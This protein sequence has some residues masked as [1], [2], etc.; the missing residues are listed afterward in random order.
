M[1]LNQF[2]VHKT[3]GNF[4][5]LTKRARSTSFLLISSANIPLGSKKREKS[6]KWAIF[7]FPNFCSFVC[8]YSLY[9]C[10]L[11][12]PNTVTKLFNQIWIYDVTGVDVTWFAQRTH[13]YRSRFYFPSTFLRS[14]KHFSLKPSS[15][16]KQRRR[17][18]RLCSM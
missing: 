11:V 12:L 16:I 9:I 6:P 2:A 15:S 1:K 10:L 4:A 13:Q 8:K 14:T 18:E 3:T 5:F 7:R 17:K